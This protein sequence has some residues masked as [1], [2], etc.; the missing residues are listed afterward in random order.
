MPPAH[1]TSSPEGPTAPV[2][3]GDVLA[4][5]YRVDRVLGIGGMGVVVAATHL[6]LHQKVA[7]KFLLPSAIEAAET[8]ERFLREARAAV[9]LRSEHVAKVIDVGTL[10]DGSPYMVMEYLDG[11][12][13]GQVIRQHGALPVA[14]A[15]GFVMQACEAV[16]EAHAAGIIHRDLKPENLFLTRR[17]DGQPLVKVLDFGIAKTTGVDL[18]LS[19]TRT[20][21]IVGSP[22]Y[23]PPEQLRSAKHVDARSDIWALG[24]VLFELLTG[25]LPF[26][27]ESFSE[28]CMKVAQDPTPRPSATR[29]EIPLELDAA[30]VRCM[31][32]VPAQRFQNVGELAMALQAFAPE[33]GPDLARRVVSVLAAGS[34]PP[35][36]LITR[37]AAT[38][39]A[40]AATG[41][42]WGQTKGGG[43]TRRRLTWLGAG[44]GLCATVGVAA[45]A[46][47][48]APPPSAAADP[49]GA[50]TRSSPPIQP[51][52]PAI[53]LSPVLATAPTLTVSATELEAS[54]P[55]TV[56]AGNA[57]NPRARTATTPASPRPATSPTVAPLPS[58]STAAAP[59]A[60]AATSGGDIVF[61]RK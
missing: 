36:H 37:P 42:S 56:T 35:G 39:P 51:D 1:G 23:M 44:V 9:R 18:Q 29:P 49:I 17:V 13:L 27:A 8:K 15:V 34:W 50:A 26:L 40:K 53:S 24:A 32:K 11:S 41:T 10:E 2:S 14:D 21:T 20:S 4:G 6:T 61:E 22:L 46:A 12:T 25:R 60:R 45:I 48:R 31:E 5:K 19:L 57:G 28:L 7:L 59:P 54:P 3:E 16:A 55:Q 38:G 58:A 33:D 43:G 30:V 52:A 47:H